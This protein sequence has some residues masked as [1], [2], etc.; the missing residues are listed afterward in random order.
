MASR[1]KRRTENV[2]GDFYVD[3]TCIDCDTCRWMVPEVFDRSG[4]QSRVH[5]Q[6]AGP[7]L[8]RAAFR[9]LIA[10]PTG[11]IGGPKG[12]GAAG[13]G[14]PK[15]PAPPGAGAPKGLC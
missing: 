2:E 10:C 12:S 11:S 13:G 15:P 4:S 3:S 6:P 5:A 14:A 9:A 1:S 8:Q 7:E